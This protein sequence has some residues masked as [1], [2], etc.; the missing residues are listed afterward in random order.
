MGQIF[1][2]LHRKLS[3]SGAIDY[4]S[5]TIKTWLLKTKNRPEKEPDLFK[6]CHCL[7]VRTFAQ[8]HNISNEDTIHHNVFN[9]IKKTNEISYLSKIDIYDA[10]AYNCIVLHKCTAID[11]L[12]MY[13]FK[14]V[15]KWS[16]FVGVLCSALDTFLPCSWRLFSVQSFARI[17][18]VNWVSLSCNDGGESVNIPLSER[19]SE[20]KKHK[21]LVFG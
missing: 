19:I 20:E 18:S 17:T 14:L 8:N 11:S 4:N 7:V 6:L 16:I 10:H 2:F 1:D 15:F 12:L 5:R 13:G 9:N 3:E 21:H